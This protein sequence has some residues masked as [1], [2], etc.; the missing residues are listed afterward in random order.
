MSQ[1][2]HAAAVVLCVSKALRAAGRSVP[3]PGILSRLTRTRMHYT[4]ICPRCQIISTRIILLAPGCS[5]VLMWVPGGSI[6]ARLL[7]RAQAVSHAEWLRGLMV[8]RYGCLHPEVRATPRSVCHSTVAPQCHRRTRPSCSEPISSSM[9]ED[10]FAEGQF[11]RIS[12]PM[13]G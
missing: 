4:P 2:T 9:L 3:C 12:T 7:N 1:L 6:P 11:G 13:V 5:D 10:G 8:G